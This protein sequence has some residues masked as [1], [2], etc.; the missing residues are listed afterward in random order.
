MLA[1]PEIAEI[2]RVADAQP[3]TVFNPFGSHTRLQAMIDKCKSV[4]QLT[5]CCQ[6]L[7]FKVSREELSGLTCAQI[8]GSKAGVDQKGL[9]DLILF[10]KNFKDALIAWG[11]TTFRDHPDVATWIQQDVAPKVH[12]FSTWTKSLKSGD[13]TWRAGRHPAEIAWLNLLT[14]ITFGPATTRPSWSP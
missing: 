5:W 13:L 1:V 4:E 3:P 11:L 7:Q 9:F 12:D 14:E 8:R 2:M 10:K 6:A